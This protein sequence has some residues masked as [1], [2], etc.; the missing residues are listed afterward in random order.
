MFLKKEWMTD[1][2]NKTKKSSLKK[3]KLS[4]YYFVYPAQSS[5][6]VHRGKYRPMGT[7]YK[8]FI[9]KFMRYPI[10]LNNLLH[11]NFILLLI[12]KINMG[13]QIIVI[14]IYTEVMEDV[15]KRPVKILKI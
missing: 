12:I 13:E 15:R 10:Y 3:H 4:V 8:V 6:Q 14:F 5:Y 9:V 1:K 7:L 11:V 2:H